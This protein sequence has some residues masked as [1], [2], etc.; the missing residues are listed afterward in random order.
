MQKKINHEKIKALESLRGLAALTVALFHYP[1]SS[2]LYLEKGFYAVNFFFILSGFVIS[3]NYANRINSLQDLIQFQIKRFYRLYPIHI[4]VLI[5]ILLIQGIKYFLIQY[6]ELS[7][8]SS[9]FG[10]RYTITDFFYNLLLIHSIFN[11]SYWLSWNPASWSISTEF[12]T[13]I[14]FG[15]I[16]YLCKNYKF[17]IIFI[18]VILFSPIFIDK[19]NYFTLI[20]YNSF[21]NGVFFQCMFNFGNGCV[22][23]FI[24]SRINFFFKDILNT[25][26]LIFIISIYYF[27]NEYFFQYNF[28]IFS[29]II[30]VFS[31]LHYSSFL[32]KLINTKPLV[33]LGTI[34][35]SFYMIHE[36]I[37]YI[38]IQTL[39]FI[40]KIE[41]ILDGNTA[42]H[43]VSSF[44]DTWIT[45]VYV[46]FSICVAYGMHKFIEL[47]FR[48]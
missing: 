36:T 7:Y 22:I 18:F 38:L 39:K 11:F 23:Y 3:Y 24:F 4:F 32:Y 5:L 17:I 48:K 29:M 14:I 6:T 9:A 21:F 12:Y 44:T 37:I 30:F 40:F 47:K 19:Y 15:L 46:F 42:V 33:F 1:S 16:F 20:N 31:K 10:S 41:F 34:S 43:A 2:F 13:Y 35:Y 28:L 8:G 25:L 27:F 45:I 26:F